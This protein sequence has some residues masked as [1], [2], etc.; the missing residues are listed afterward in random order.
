VPRE[1]NPS[2]AKRLYI[3]AFKN[4]AIPPHREMTVKN[5]LQQEEKNE[6]DF[7]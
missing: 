3:F 4:S 2:V 5:H 7:I 6:K 1:K